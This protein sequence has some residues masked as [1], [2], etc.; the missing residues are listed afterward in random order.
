MADRVVLV[1]LDGV[2]IGD[3]PDAAA[4]GDAGSNSVA[5]TA[6]V[7]GGMALPHLEA[8]GLGNLAEIEGVPPRR[9]TLG[10]YGR[11]TERSPGKDTVTG[12]WEMAGIV[13]TRPQPTYPQGFPR[14][15]VAEFERLTGRGVLG[16]VPASGTEII[17]ALGDE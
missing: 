5:N 8:L 13:T 7:L 14:E 11:L 4:Y 2:G 1:V 15:V 10:P 16:N 6:R 3:A 9:E 17:A 12:H